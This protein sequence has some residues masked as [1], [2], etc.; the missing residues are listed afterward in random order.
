MDSLSDHGQCH[1]SVDSHAELMQDQDLIGVMKY[2]GICAGLQV[3]QWHHKRFDVA[4]VRVPRWQQSCQMLRHGGA[5]AFLNVDTWVVIAGI[6]I[7]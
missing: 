6:H 2:L 7:I 5:S 4:R 1:L 3:K